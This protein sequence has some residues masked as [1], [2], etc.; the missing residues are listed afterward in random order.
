MGVQFREHE[1]KVPLEYRTEYHRDRDRIVWSRTFK[2]L[3]HKTQVFPHY[4][5]DH[6]RRRLTHSLEVSQIATTLAR[7]LGL[8]EVA[9]EAMAL[10]HDLGHTPFGHSGES[11]LNEE[12]LSLCPNPMPVG[13]IPI[14]GF[15]HCVHA[16]EVVSR[17]ETEY[18]D[19]SGAGPYG[20]NLTFDV[21][22]G[23]LKH[24]FDQTESYAERPFS[25]IGDVVKF[26][27]Y[28]QFGDN[29]GCLEAQC[30]YLADK[31]AYLVS[32]IED[33]IRCGI[34]ACAELEEE[35]FLKLIWEK[36]QKERRVAIPLQLK[37][38]NDYLFFRRAAL[39]LIILDCIE[40]SQKAIDYHGFEK[41]GDARNCPHRIITVSAELRTAWDE[42]GNTWMKNKLY[43]DPDVVACNFK[44]KHIVRDL[45]KAY[46][47]N[48]NLIDKSYRD[49]SKKAYDA[50]GVDDSDNFVMVRNYIAGM[51][52][53]FATEQ[54]SRLYMSSERVR[55]S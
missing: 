45:F 28:A 16:I 24:M 38:V 51:T 8:N 12:M 17:I 9:T 31:L 42:F 33:G 29:K 4:M 34:F 18:C 39:A 53:A 14:Y 40:T 54:H 19:P 35:R 27:Q 55:F 41:P 23:I 10:G 32:D 15:D 2:R 49:H 37:S 22:D 46:K 6:Y 47:D 5:Q 20:L 26:G 3:Q 44:A 48:P 11:A 43:I 7:S 1:E 30:L 36:Y 13:P 50:I 52:D 21:R 25:K